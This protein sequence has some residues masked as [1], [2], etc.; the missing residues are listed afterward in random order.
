MI[1]GTHTSTVYQLNVRTSQSPTFMIALRFLFQ[2][3]QRKANSAQP[4]TTY[5]FVR[6]RLAT[7]QKDMR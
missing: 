7:L 3:R 2:S 5:L 4:H 1:W 6:T